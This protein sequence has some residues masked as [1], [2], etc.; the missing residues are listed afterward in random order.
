MKSD[1]FR[2]KSLV[3]FSLNNPVLVI[4]IT[5][6]AM[7]AA[8]GL[9]RRMPVDVFPDLDVPR[10]VIQTEAG[11]LTAEEVEQFVSIPLESAMNGLPGVTKVRSSSGGGLSF[12]WVDFAWGT[13]LYRARQLVAERLASV[14]EGLPAAAVPEISPMT[15]V[16][17]EILLLALTCDNN[18]V[19]ELELRALAEFDL[20]NRLLAVSG[21]GQVVVIGG[22]LPECQVNVQPELLQ[23][24]GVTLRDVVEATGQAGTMAS[25]GYLPNTGGMEFPLRQQA[26]VAS[27]E[28]LRQAIVSWHNGVPLTLGQVADVRIGGAPR[29]G[30]A[31]NNG[32]PAV[33]LSVQKVPA[34]NT[35]E[36]TRR[37]DGV[38]EDFSASRLPKGV[39]LDRLA[40]RQADF[41]GTSVSNGL[42]ILR[43]SAIVVAIILILFLMNVRTAL[44]TL[45]AM[46]VSLGLALLAFPAFGLGINI[47]TLGGL[48]VAVGDV[49]DNAIIFVEIAHRRLR[50]NRG[51]PEA[52]RR[53]VLA[54][55]MS[56]S[57]EI[58]S[59]VSFATVIIALVFV[60]LLFLGGLEGQ[61]F[62]PLGIAYILAMAASLLV[63]VTL[64][65]A[66]CKLLLA[67]EKGDSHA[68]TSESI[69]SRWLKRLYAPILEACLHWRTSVC[70]ATLALTL[71]CCWLASTF[72]TSFLPT[73]HEG[74]Y[75]VFLM[76][77]PGT[78][79]DESDRL[80]TQVERGLGK[81]PGVL[82]VCRRT[83]RA[84][85]DEHAEPVSNSEIQLRVD[86]AA[87]QK[88]IRAAIDREVAGIPG[89][90]AIIGQPIA[91]RISAV[92]SGTNA[93]VT[94]NIFGNDLEQLRRLTAEVKGI[95]A[96]IPAARDVAANRE[97]IVETIRIRYRLQD[98]ARWGLSLAE[99][100]EQ[101]S[102]AFNGV[103]MGEITEDLQRR[104]IVVRLEPGQRGDIRDV[105]E[106]M[107]AGRAG[108][109]VRLREVADI[110]R[111]EASNLIVREST[112]RKSLLTCNV[113]EE[114]N[115]GHLVAQIRRQVDPVVR[116][117][118]CTVAYSGQ[119]EAQQSAVRLLFW[120]GLLAVAVIVVLLVLALRS[121]KTA[122]L[123]LVN[124][125]L[126]LIGG[127]IAIYVC[128][129]APMVANTLALLGLKKGA[130]L[131]PVVSVAAVVGYVTLIGMAIRNG[132][133]LLNRCREFQEG[134]M[135]VREAILNGARERLLPILMTALVTALGL[136]PVARAVGEPG[137]ELLAPLALVQL[138]GL[139][140]STF[141]T[142][143]VLPAAYS[144]VFDRGASRGSK[145]LRG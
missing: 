115:L 90:A 17:G 70:V 34:S 15:S 71:A 85:R 78:S 127:I 55:M 74:C 1:P 117:E 108:V 4:V 45:L 13:D 134:G 60:P 50:E 142:L 30:T 80:A 59:S 131:A 89:A 95:L 139:L 54:V 76:T 113:A 56:A 19:S 145:G 66:L 68:A 29:R 102:A 72:G 62:R 120:A 73:F 86:L 7:L 23:L 22:R 18:A 106:L 37:I 143:L 64:T 132:L 43:D 82:G 47:M 32:R 26:R 38:L 67:T 48:A 97:V 42:R 92:L 57:S 63:A 107:L 46:P 93:E 49:V 33:V 96:A 39:K 112:R 35:L 128:H 129:E 91:H 121:F 77:P 124:L 79:L 25:A 9:L 8:F 122:L 83:G 104:D 52:Q 133:L 27:A 110:F 99:V 41:I 118:G 16:T 2:L 111:E 105:G 136:F 14:K 36:L 87:D 123:V 44:I 31:S 3:D 109:Q 98:L 84:E 116:R 94:I 75:T 130:Y 88:A 119:F 126:A 20:R 11:G 125:P 28:D 69:T 53:P 141:L 21:I 114:S 61:F 100:G 10:V 5:L 137:G 65:P 101:V 138:G 135:P 12:V 144:L 40:Y 24:H 6:A 103:K 140:S 58:L 51:Q 81:I